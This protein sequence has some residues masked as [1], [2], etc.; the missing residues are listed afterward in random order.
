MAIM[1]DS[2]TVLKLVV[3]REWRNPERIASHFPPSGEMPLVAL[4]HLMDVSSRDRLWVL[5]RLILEPGRF[6]ILPEALVD[7]LVDTQGLENVYG[8]AERLWLRTTTDTDRDVLAFRILEPLRECIEAWE[9]S[10]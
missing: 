7:Q 5:H 6:S 8:Y 3:C 10:Q 1:I 9:E 2:D 4:L